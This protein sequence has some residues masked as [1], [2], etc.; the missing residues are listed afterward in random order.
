MNRM[1][2]QV[3]VATSGQKRGGGL[4]V[5]STENINAIA[6]EN[7]GSVDQMAKASEELVEAAKALMQGIE[8]FKA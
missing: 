3:T 5:R 1:T 2:Q 6:K 7:Q 8:S 4:V